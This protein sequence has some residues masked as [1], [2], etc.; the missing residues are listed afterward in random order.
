MIGENEGEAGRPSPD[1]AAAD[2]ALPAQPVI[3]RFGGIRPMAQKLGVP[4][5]TVQGWKERGAI[6]AN[7]REEVLAA[8]ERHAIVWEPGDLSVRTKT[9][10]PVS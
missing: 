9:S 2:G 4:V 7:R 6:P 8:A 1:A 10:S 5:S 3:Q